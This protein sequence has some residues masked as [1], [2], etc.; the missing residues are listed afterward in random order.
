MSES[1]HPSDD[2][3]QPPSDLVQYDDVPLLNL[4]SNHTLYVNS[5]LMFNIL[6]I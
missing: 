5:K 1:Q 4:V 3:T 6:M 2:E